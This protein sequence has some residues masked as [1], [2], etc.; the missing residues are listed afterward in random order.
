ML[1]L[2][3]W[4]PVLPARKMTYFLLYKN[5]STKNQ[6]NKYSHSQKGQNDLAHPRELLLWNSQQQLQWHLC[7]S[8]LLP[9]PPHP[10]S[11]KHCPQQPQI[12]WFLPP[13]RSN[14]SSALPCLCAQQHGLHHPACGTIFH[15]HKMRGASP[16]HSPPRNELL[17]QE[18]DLLQVGCASLRCVWE[19]GQPAWGGW[20]DDA[21]WAT[22][23]LLV[24][25]A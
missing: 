11:P 14:T 18:V 5:S 4:L 7:C 24:E 17:H 1:L 9:L 15:L 12:K 10:Q 25:Q 13:L 16:R 22:R 23:K 19:G 3:F 8:N 21:G 6:N 2:T 20:M